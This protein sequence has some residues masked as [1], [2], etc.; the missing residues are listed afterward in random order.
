MPSG[1]F[2]LRGGGVMG[3]LLPLAPCCRRRIACPSRG[4]GLPDRVGW[5]LAMIGAFLDPPAREAV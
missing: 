2:E 1:L 4:F 5:L 3:D